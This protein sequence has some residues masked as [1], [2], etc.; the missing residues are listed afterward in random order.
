VIIRCDVTRCGKLRSS[1]RRLYSSSQVSIEAAQDCWSTC[2]TSKMAPQHGVHLEVLQY[3][4]WALVYA[5]LE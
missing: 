5:S 1:L 3:V 2:L 4:N